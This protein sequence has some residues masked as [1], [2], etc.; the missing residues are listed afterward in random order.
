MYFWL[1][2][3]VF[4]ITDLLPSTTAQSKVPKA[5]IYMK[6]LSVSF[7]PEKIGHAHG[8][9]ISYLKEERTRNLFVYHESGQV[10]VSWFNAIRATQ[11]AYLQRKHPT[12]EDNELIPQ[13]SRC[14]LK[15]GYMEKTGPMDALELG[16]VFIGTENYGYSVTGRR[17]PGRW[18]WGIAMT[19]PGRQFIFMCEQEQDQRE[20]LEALRE[21]IS[22]PMTLQD[23]A[24]EANWRRRK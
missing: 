15:E 24:N 10:I 13:I 18:N 9:Q 2:S 21:V 12:V 19:T 7:Q 8:L 3:R 16:A 11:L 23:Y 20:W 4:C 1:N 22:R 14:C 6:D 17:R 5:V